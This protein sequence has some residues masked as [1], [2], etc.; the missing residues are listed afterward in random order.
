MKCFFYTLLLLVINS[1]LTA[2]SVSINTS[3]ATA[4]AS[5]ILDISSTSKGVLVPR[6]TKA[7]KN[8][9]A[10]PATALLIYQA[11]PDSI[12]FHYYNGSQWVWLNPSTAASNDWSLTGNTGT[13][14]A[15]N[16]IGTTDN[17]PIRFKQGNEWLGQW[18][19]N[20]G[21]YFIGEMT[22]KKT[23]SGTDNI[24]IGDSS[25]LNNT[26]SSNL[27][28]I[29]RRTLYSVTT[30]SDLIAIG[31]SALYTNT[32]GNSNIA[33]GN[34]ALRNNTTGDFNFVLGQN[35]LQKNTTGDQNIAIA[36]SVLANNTTGGSNIG[37]GNEALFKNT[38]GFNN[39]AIGR[40]ALYENTTGF[41]NIAIGVR[42]METNTTGNN[43][44]S[45]GHTAMLDNI[46]GSYNTAFGVGAAGGNTSGGR[47][48]AIGAL[49]LYNNTEGS[50]NIAVGYIALA[51]NE[52]GNYNIAIGDS[53]AAKTLT[54]NT[55]AI[56][57]KSLYNNVNGT[58]N[59]VL[60][61]Q[62]GYNTTGSG[63]VFLG[64]HAGRNETGSNKLYID[65]SNTASPLLYGDFNTDLL[66]VNGTLNI[67]NDY[68]FPVADG[69]P[70]QVL[71]TNGSGTVSWATAGGI[72]T[73]NNG[74]TLTGSNVA[75]GGT[76]LANTS[77][78]QGNF[79]LTHS[80]NGTG[81]LLVSTLTNN[82][83]TVLNNG[84]VGIHTNNPQYKLHIINTVGGITNLSNSL[85]IQNTNA[86]T[87]GQAI[88]AFKNGG[89]DG[90]P[91]NRAWI[92][93]MNAY[94]NYVIAYGDSLTG[95]DA[96]IR[97][98]TAGYVGI[99]PSAFPNSRLDVVGSFG[100]GIRVTT[101]S[102][103]L[104]EDD[105]T[106]IIGPAAG[107][108]LVTLPAASGVERREYVIVNRG[109]SF[110]SISS[111]QDFSG[112]ST[113]LA[114]NSAISIQSNGINWFRIR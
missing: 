59:T 102:T 108:V 112:S 82:A 93:G 75:L 97:V 91:G 85:M 94:D 113:N 92:T 99:N 7:Q 2:Q 47:N 4:N 23:T 24:A 26:S 106:L 34:K 49:C 33:I 55:V 45:V 61:S 41:T 35:S 17:M 31:D 76:L 65:N 39:F 1:N 80:L 77:I 62:A 64:Y 42:N 66:R 86:S 8:A 104:D 40:T 107:S 105:H 10:S 79:N 68:S 109:S 103:T 63:N 87:T 114:S 72:A 37:I 13:D 52:T 15:T 11:S 101:A 9:I 96:I 78:S 84:N 12:G 18:N 16:F 57:S 27:I 14:T 98:D 54:S 5:S 20:T 48:V 46:T 81:D 44:T 100:N 38:S 56:G 60:G 19:K 30:G 90:L 73:A 3:G 111:Y 22:G 29:G 28:G 51:D 74:L 43:N 21:N 95:S 88:L 50:S 110:Q 53:A 71:Q 32:T 69:G 89:P 67:N 6:M 70:N 36:E 83:F 58:N 25:I